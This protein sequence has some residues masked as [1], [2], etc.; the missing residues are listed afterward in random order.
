[1]S[2][3]QVSDTQVSDADLK[4]NSK[5]SIKILNYN[6]MPDSTR[7]KFTIQSKI[8]GQSSYITSRLSSDE[9]EALSSQSQQDIIKAAFSKKKDNV[10]TVAKELEGR[11]RFLGQEYFGTV[12]TD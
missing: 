7:V 12:E 4:D 8:T 1:M 6:V 3:T 10:K 9:I 2:D 5:F 11:S